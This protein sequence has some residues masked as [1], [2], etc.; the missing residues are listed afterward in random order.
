[1][2]SLCSSGAKFLEGIELKHWVVASTLTAE[3]VDIQGVTGLRGF[4]RDLGKFMVQYGMRVSVCVCVAAAVTGVV[5]WF[6]HTRVAMS[7]V[8]ARGYGRMR[9]GVAVGVEGWGV[10]MDWAGVLV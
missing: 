3:E 4:L 10:G 9:S 1:M 6:V 7:V 8:G 5:A 2:K